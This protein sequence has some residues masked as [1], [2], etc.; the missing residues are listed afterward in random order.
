MI[1]IGLTGGIA[2]GK[3]F[4]ATYIKKLTISTHESDLVV[5]NLYKKKDKK[6]ILFLKKRGFK[7]A[8]AEKTIKKN[9][10]RD[11]ILKN[12]EKR[13]LLEN[14]I[15]K[16][17]KKD[18]NLFL[19]KN[20]N[21]KIVVLD[22]PLLFEKK[23]N[24]ICNY[25]CSTIAPINLRQKR[26]LKR[27]GMTTQIFKNIVKKQVKDKDRKKKSQFTINTSKSKLDTC[28]QIDNMLYCVLKKI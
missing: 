19:N 28:L 1:V 3:T 7:D 10:I 23:L 16:E 27:A 8:V 2:S 9:I 26:A 17:V 14:Y 5:S 11:E 12:D 18:R 6:L 20:K 24:N 4:V 25:V 15:H 13:I 22:I 21:Q